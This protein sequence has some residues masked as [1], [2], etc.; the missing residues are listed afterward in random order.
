M[1]R[2]SANVQPYTEGDKFGGVAELQI[3]RAEVSK[4]GTGIN[5][6]ASII[7]VV[8]I[9]GQDTV[10]DE[11]RNKYDGKEIARF[12]ISLEPESYSDSKGYHMIKDNSTKF[13]AQVDV[14]SSGF[15]PS[16]L[17][18]KTFFARIGVKPDQDKVW[19]ESVTGILM[20][21]EVAA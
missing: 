9:T 5:I 10:T 20:P 1:N 14:D 17:E 13:F 19:T 15:D 7:D 8:T 12:W 4:K 21:D 16:A 18:D 2:V 11:D 3:R 6:N